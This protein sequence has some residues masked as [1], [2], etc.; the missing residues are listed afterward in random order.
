MYSDAHIRMLSNINRIFFEQFVYIVRKWCS[1]DF[2]QIRGFPCRFDMLKNS[3]IKLVVGLQLK[4]LQS[5]L[6]DMLVHEQLLL[7]LGLNF[8]DELP[9]REPCLYHQ[10]VFFCEEPQFLSSSGRKLSYK[11][12]ICV[13]LYNS[14][15][16]HL[17]EPQ[18]GSS[19]GWKLSHTRCLS[20]LRAQNGCGI[21][22]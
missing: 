3:Y 12:Y 22:L 15:S 10:L 21:H 8:W 11:P 17:Q 14:C 16:I 9:L 19:S 18:F 6:V 4:W 2:E 7:L 20:L 5:R 13:V 1:P